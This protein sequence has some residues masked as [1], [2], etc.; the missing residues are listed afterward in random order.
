MRKWEIWPFLEPKSWRKYDISWLLESSCFEL[1]TD[2]K[3]GLSFQP[4]SWWKDYIYVVFLSFL[5]YSMTWEICFFAQC[6]SKIKNLFS[7]LWSF[8]EFN[9]NITVTLITTPYFMFFWCWFS[10]I[11]L[12]YLLAQNWLLAKC[13]LFSLSFTTSENGPNFPSIFSVRTTKTKNFV[14]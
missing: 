5:W 10:S 4:K 11:F 3:Y 7:V 14:M 13:V 12:F 1:F 6:T 2:G 8:I 9:G